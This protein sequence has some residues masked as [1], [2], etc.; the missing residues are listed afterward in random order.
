MSNGETIQLHP[1][2]IYYNRELETAYVHKFIPGKK[3]YGWY[4]T[5][6]DDKYFLYIENDSAQAI[7]VIDYIPRQN[8]YI[9]VQFAGVYEPDIF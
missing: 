2:Y 7:V 5:K 9:Q 1:S 3:G 8:S 4:L 6:K